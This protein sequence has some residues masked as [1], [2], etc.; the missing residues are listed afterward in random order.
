MRFD[1]EDDIIAKR[2]G[3]NGIYQ[4]QLVGEME[5][6]HLIMSDQVDSDIYVLQLKMESAVYGRMAYIHYF[7]LDFHYG[8]VA[9]AMGTISQTRC[10]SQ[11]SC[12][13]RNNSD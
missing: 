7:D 2:M 10:E 12:T 3:Y 13:D 8:R 9:L 1:N 5:Q 6:N 11:Q 4:K